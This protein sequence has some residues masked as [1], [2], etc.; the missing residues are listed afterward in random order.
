MSLRTWAR[1]QLVKG[2]GRFRDPIESS[3]EGPV[4]RILS[5]H[6]I[7]AGQQVAFQHQLDRLQ[8]QYN[9]VTPSEFRHR[10]GDP[11]RLNLLLSFDDG[12]LDWESQ[13]LPELTQRDIRAVFFLCPDLVGLDKQHAAEYCR[14]HLRIEP[15][16]A[17]T[18]D[19]AQR[20]REEGHQLGNHL[21]RHTDLRGLSDESEIYEILQESRERFHDLFGETTEWMAY[22]FGDYFR[23]PDPLRSCV[24]G[25]FERAFT[26]VPG[27]ND[28]A[29]DP[30]FLRRDAFSP[31]YSAGLERAWLSGGYDPLFGLTHLTRPLP[32]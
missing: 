16:L 18:V 1:N 12:Y 32:G 25:Y 21:V 24:D 10:Q 28:S 30:L 4:F 31:D 19:G 14:D 17:L 22:P 13:V 20:I 8:K 5:Y 9:I 6:R 2:L 7:R 27:T 23:F 11:D 3:R 15:A 29:A 26:L